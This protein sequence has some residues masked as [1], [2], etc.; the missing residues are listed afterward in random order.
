MTATAVRCEPV[1]AATHDAVIGLKVLPEQKDFVASNKRSMKLARKRPEAEP[2]ALFHGSEL[3]GFAL[4]IPLPDTPGAVLLER[5]MI[6]RRAQGRGLGRL[7]MRA[8][9]ERCRADGRTTVRLSVVPGNRVAIGL[10]RSLG[11]GETGEVE[12]G[13]TVMELT[14][15]DTDT[16]TDTGT[17]T[18]TGTAASPDR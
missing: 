8:V 3:V 11:F 14:W 17:G 4:L 9:L 12:D 5:F 2:L 16:D 15:P 10:Y 7:G 6:D 1:T 18:G 13:E